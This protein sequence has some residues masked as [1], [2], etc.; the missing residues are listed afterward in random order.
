MG[1]SLWRES[2]FNKKILE[3]GKSKIII[4]SIMQGGYLRLQKFVGNYII[5]HFIFMK[6]DFTNF[7]N[8]LLLIYS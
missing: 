2:G 6:H 7:T 8:L 5:D 1:R 4:S 3:S